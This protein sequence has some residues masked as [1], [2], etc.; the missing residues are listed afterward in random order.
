MGFSSHW[1]PITEKLSFTISQRADQCSVAMELDN[2]KIEEEESREASTESIYFISQTIVADFFCACVFFC[3]ICP[4]FLLKAQ[5]M[6]LLFWRCYQS[7]VVPYEYLKS[8]FCL[9]LFSD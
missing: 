7:L 1:N 5:Y 9:N 6:A 8:A 4:L 2:R 3:M